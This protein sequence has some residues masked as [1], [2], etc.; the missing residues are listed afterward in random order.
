MTP[1]ITIETCEAYSILKIHRL[2]NL[3]CERERIA[4]VNYVIPLIMAT[5]NTIFSDM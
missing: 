3:F 5:A 1:C 2:D 4:L